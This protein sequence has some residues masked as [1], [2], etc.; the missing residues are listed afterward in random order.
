[1]RAFS[2]SPMHLGSIPTF[3]AGR[4]SKGRQTTGV[5]EEDEVLDKIHAVQKINSSCY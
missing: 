3:S 4:A 2:A 1:M 5:T